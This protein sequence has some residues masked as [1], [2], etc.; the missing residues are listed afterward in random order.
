MDYQSIVKY[1]WSLK[2]FET[3]PP[4]SG[5]AYSLDRV[6]ELLNALGN[7]Q[8]KLAIIHVAG[9]K[10]KGSTTIYLESIIRACGYKTGCY[11]SPH[12][13]SPR[14]R[15]SISGKPIT[16]EE[17]VEVAEIIIS[18][19][20]GF[21]E[22]TSFEFLTAMAFLKFYLENVDFVVLEVGLGG[23]L[24]ATNTIET[25]LV[26]VITPIS[27]DHS[28][29]L[30]STLD[31]IAFEKA[32]IIK[33]STPVVVSKQ[34]KV[35]EKTIINVAETRNAPYYLVDNIVSLTRKS[36]WLNG[37]TFDVSFSDQRLISGVESKSV[38]NLFLPLLG[39]HQIENAATALTAIKIIPDNIKCS[40]EN[41]RNGLAN[42]VWPCR[43]EVVSTSP[44]VM[45]DGAHNDASSRALARTVRELKESNV[46]SWDHLTLVLGISSDKDASSIFQPLM[47]L[48]DNL[49]VTRANHPRSAQISEVYKQINRFSQTSMV[50]IPA[51]LGYEKL[52]DAV[53]KSMSLAG[54]RGAVII[55]G[56]LFLA[57]E[58]RLIFV[59]DV[60]D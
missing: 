11:T 29:V 3:N 13:F 1:I 22:L 42:A 17:F 16:K 8:N 30:G 54:V 45:I 32:G 58:A 50:E 27:F 28:L 48:V 9:T 23:R 44:F 59:N 20:R 40:V 37:Q 47:H 31:K 24:D 55:T 4:Q 34:I 5:D 26:S 36:Q 56:S 43:T 41:I 7:P 2:N 15:I 10:G 33:Q 35:A 18:A 49:I 60:V 51:V 46:V 39:F 19:S 52:S 6:F 53:S 12:L 25:S 38:T 14:E 57:A 21:T